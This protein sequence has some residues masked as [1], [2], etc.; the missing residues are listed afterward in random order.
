MCKNP[1]EGAISPNKA[2]EQAKLALDLCRLASDRFQ[3]RRR[4]EWQVNLALW[5][6]LVL[7]GYAL[8]QWSAPEL[9][10][11]ILSF[12]FLLVLLLALNVLYVFFRYSLEQR[13]WLDMGTSY[14]WES[15]AQS[16]GGV[17]NMPARFHPPREGWVEY[18]TAKGDAREMQRQVPAQVFTWWNLGIWICITLLFSLVPA[19]VLIIKIT[20][21]WGQ[22]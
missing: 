17:G 22:E 19:L 12:F 14:Y 21:M 11:L 13:N 5:A 4:I 2:Q 16:L 15:C 6:W 3:A 18:E 8:L 10:V 9:G 1:E 7:I 20:E